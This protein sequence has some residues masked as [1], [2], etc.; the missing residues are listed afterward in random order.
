MKVYFISGLG[1]DE[2]VFQFLDLPGVIQIHI[3]WT[4]PADKEPLSKYAESLISQIDQHEPVNLIGISFGGVIA[5]EIA[6][7]IPCRRIIILSSVKSPAE[8]SWQLSFIAITKIHRLFPASFLKW[9]NTLTADY[10]FSTRSKKE[11]ELLHR[12][13]KETDNHFMLWA[14]DQLM[15]WKNPEPLTNMVHI[16]GTADR[17]FPKSP[18]KNY[19][20]V[21]DG[22][23]FMVVNKSVELSRKILENL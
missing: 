18:V 14:I 3:K 1:A 5:Q 22:G 7:L 4:N 19:I 9:S 16:H 17:I 12:I 23:H 10:Y 15:R 2:R 11:S 20:P 21:Q 13:I 8:Y 6:K